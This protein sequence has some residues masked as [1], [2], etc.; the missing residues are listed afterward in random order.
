MNRFFD[1][2]S[3]QLKALGLLSAIAVLAGVYLLV[4][5]YAVPAEQAPSIEMHLGSEDRMFTGLFL[6]DPNTAPAD[7][8]ELLPGIGSVLADRIVEYRRHNRFESPV[9]IT[10]VKGIGPKM[11][12]RIKPYLRVR[13]H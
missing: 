3:R 4:H 10:E 6:V 8:L 9:D 12:E 13:Q 7:S 5:A 2:S 11:Y 1:F